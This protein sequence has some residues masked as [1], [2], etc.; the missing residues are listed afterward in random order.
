MMPEV[1]L[2]IDVEDWY[3]GM[4]VLGEPT[5][6]PAGARSG[7]EGLAEHLAAR[8]SADGPAPRVTLFVVGNYVDTVADELAGLLASGHEL[9]SHGPDHGHLPEEYSGLVEWLRTGRCALEDR[10]QAPVKGFRSPRFD[11]PAAIGLDGFRSAIAEAGFEYVSDTH[12]LG[13]ASPVRELPV[14]SFHG[15]P[16]G[17]GSYQR[18]L[19]VPVVTGSVNRSDGPVVLYYHSYDFGATLPRVSSI[20][21]LAVAK[22]LLGRSRVD[23]AFSAVLSRYGSKACV[24]VQR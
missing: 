1:C 24:D 20:R 8:P 9:A 19:P 15:F 22:Q 23:K 12:V 10:F 17:G 3:D 2:S 18:L 4:E 6:K 13:E 21:T 14:L 7:L 11:R 5:P 16:M